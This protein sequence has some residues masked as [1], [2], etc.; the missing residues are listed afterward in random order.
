MT[1]KQ[2]SMEE[3]IPFPDE[4]AHLK[5][6][7]TKLDIAVR[8][9]YA[10]VE[11]ID[12]NYMEAKQYMIDNRGDIDPHEMF[13][14]ERS[15]QQIDRTGAFAVGIWDKLSKQKESPYFARIDFCTHDEPAETKYYIGRF[16]FI[17][18]EEPIIFDWRA[19]VSSMFYDCEV[20]DAFYEAPIGKI[21]GQLTLKRQF[22]IKNGALEYAIESSV[23]IR[24]DVL[25]KELSHTSDEKMK[26]IIATIQ[27]EQNQII[28]DERAKTIIIQGVAGS[29]KTSI[30]LHRIAFLL[31]RLKDRLVAKNVTIISP[32]KVFGDYISTVLPELGEEPIAEISFYDIA[33]VQLGGV[34]NFQ[35]DKDPLETSDEAW[36]GRIRFKS[37]WDF[38]KLMNQYIAELPSFVFEPASCV[39]G[40]LSVRKEWIKNRFLSYKSYPI[41]KRLE[42]IAEDINDRFISE[43]YTGEEVPKVKA[44]LK[45]LK[46]MLTIKSTVALYKHF[47]QWIGYP[48]MFS[49]QNKQTLEWADVF[50]FMYLYG[51]FE[52]L[53]V[54]TLIKHLVVDEMQDYTPIQ[55]ATINKLF[56]CQKTILGDFGQFVNP[57]H[58]HNLDDMMAL[59]GDAHLVELNKSYRSTYEIIN[60]AKSIQKVNKL[61]PMER[62]GEEPLIIGCVS[63]DEELIK[64]KAMIEAFSKGGGVSLGIIT[65][66][67]S[68]AQRLYELLSQNK[69]IQLITP[70]S[71]RF[72]NGISITSI[73]MSKGLEFDEVIVVDANH[74]V[75][76]NDCD[77]SLLYIAAT[78]AM[79]KLT[80]LYVGKPS[81]YLSK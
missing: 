52:G 10:D 58:L 38:V 55:Y 11:K 24:D 8:E 2:S 39:F 26:S 59:Y 34:I 56:P 32:N 28:R 3:Q 9:A 67:N 27:K 30:A 76:Y 19:P 54:S 51:A 6:I 45:S 14:N 62:H 7:K 20:G 12:K 70:N 61:E 68:E 48:E 31:Y 66:T 60:F 33:W 23:N 64:I 35:Q 72:I 69:Q 37:T 13:Q 47:Y 79:H 81:P 53:K 5:D 40:R 1:K 21:E 65:K 42:L 49:M 18:E 44:I 25:Q 15:L 77:R 36:A 4:I 63:A 43:N 75:Y 17:H 80:V 78:R 16:A 50:P 74:D 57:N 71:T 29:G 46:A 73:Q 22:K 41:K